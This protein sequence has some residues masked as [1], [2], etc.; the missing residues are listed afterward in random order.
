MNEII[1]MIRYKS[2]ENV[3]ANKTQNM[4]EV[5]DPVK[6]AEFESPRILNTHVN[7]RY[8][9]LYMYLYTKTQEIYYVSTEMDYSQV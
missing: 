3:K 7:F 2:A 5:A 6:L 8:S 1:H 9:C 4:L